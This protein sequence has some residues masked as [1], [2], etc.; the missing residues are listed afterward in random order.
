[1][2]NQRCISHHAVSIA[3]WLPERAVVQAQLG[4][5]LAGRELKI[6]Q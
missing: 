6:I 2:K 1:V 5:G 4:Q 3:S